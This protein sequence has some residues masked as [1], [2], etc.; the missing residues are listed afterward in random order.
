M[1][2][3]NLVKFNIDGLKVYTSGLTTIKHPELMVYVNDPTLISEAE[4]FLRY[5]C[6]YIYES[7][8]RLEAGQTLA[9][10]YWLTKFIATNAGLLE[11]WEY[12]AEATHFVPGATLTLTYWRDQHQVCKKM[13]AEFKPPRPDKLAVISAGVLES[14]IP[15]QAVRYPSPEHMS[16][17][18][19]ITNRYGGNTHSLKTTH[20]YHI[21]SIR[22]ELAPYIALPYGF[23]FQVGGDEYIRFD[24]SVA[25]ESPV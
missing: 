12:N 7:K 9:Y 20:M 18:W 2:G 15:I 6:R 13:Q 1:S 23:R 21:T 4:I 11:I 5:I 24:Q 22:P 8:V 19:L 10:G 25:N 16:G 14:D 17:W 3:I